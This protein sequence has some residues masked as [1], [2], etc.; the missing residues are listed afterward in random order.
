MHPVHFG[1]ERPYSFLR[2]CIIAQISLNGCRAAPNSADFIRNAGG[3]QFLPPNP[4]AIEID[5]D[6]RDIRAARAN[7]SAI[8]RPIPLAAPVTMATFPVCED[9]SSSFK[10][11]L[12]ALTT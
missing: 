12:K 2:G 9:I 11:T 7:R 4:G 8:A 5:I 10:A 1:D 3:A 6:N